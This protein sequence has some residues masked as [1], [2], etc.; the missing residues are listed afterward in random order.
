MAFCF[1]DHWSL[2]GMVSDS[3]RLISKAAAQH[4]HA[5][6]AAA[7]AAVYSACLLQA[8]YGQQYWKQ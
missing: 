3:Q 6:A 5:A 8:R 7:A 1:F 4:V 2:V